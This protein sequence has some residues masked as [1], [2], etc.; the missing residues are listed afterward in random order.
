MGEIGH[1][2]KNWNEFESW[3]EIGANSKI[4]EKYEEFKNRSDIGMDIKMGERL[5]QFQKSERDLRQIKK[6]N[7][8]E[9]MTYS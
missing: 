9:T 3:E 6:R 5:E 7:W 2:F 1:G 4:A 8:R